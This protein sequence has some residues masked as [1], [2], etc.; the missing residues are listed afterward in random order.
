MKQ[1]AIIFL[2]SLT[3]VACQPKNQQAEK[4][5]SF[6]SPK[7][8]MTTDI[9][10][11]IQTPNVIQTQI[12]ELSF[13]DG[14]PQNIKLATITE[15]RR[16]KLKTVKEAHGYMRHRNSSN[17]NNNRKN[18]NNQN[19][20]KNKNNNYYRKN[21]NDYTVLTNYNNNNI[22]KLCVVQQFVVVLRVFGLVVVCQ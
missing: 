21:K 20:N 15:R 1:I 12:G 22:T 2:A 3:L 6:E 13:F 5:Q 10:E 7:M 18:R 16:L 4:Q 14:I 11:G 8:A 9:P 17:N 19:K